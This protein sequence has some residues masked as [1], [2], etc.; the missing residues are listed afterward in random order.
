MEMTSWFDMPH[1]E[2]KELCSEHC[3]YSQHCFFGKKEIGKDPENCSE[4]I[5]LEDYAWDAEQ[6]R[7]AELKERELEYEPEDNDDWEE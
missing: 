1:D 2:S 7:I 3:R 4:Y 5:K 6:E